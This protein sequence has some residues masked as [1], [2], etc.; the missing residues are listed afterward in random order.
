[1]K[2]NEMYILKCIFYVYNMS[3]MRWVGLIKMDPC[4]CMCQ[5]Y[6]SGYN[7]NG[8]V[9]KRNVQAEQ[10]QRDEIGYPAKTGS[11]LSSIVFAVSP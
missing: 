2:T 7:N 6:L 8:N 4:P 1:M 3:L 10:H 5:Q 11:S 9:I